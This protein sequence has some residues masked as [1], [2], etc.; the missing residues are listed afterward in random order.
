MLMKDRTAVVTGAARG[1][2]RAGSV[3]NFSEGA[4]T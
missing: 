1:I 4:E 3:A 2:G